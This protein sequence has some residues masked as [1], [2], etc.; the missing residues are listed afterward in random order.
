MT[1]HA[2]GD[3]VAVAVAVGGVMDDDEEGEEDKA[4]RIPQSSL[5][6]DALPRMGRWHVASWV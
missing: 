6:D 3:I 2:D 4:G 5:R 1:W